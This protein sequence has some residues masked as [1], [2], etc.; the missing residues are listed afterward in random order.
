MSSCG[1]SLIHTAQI[2]QIYRLPFTIYQY[3]TMDFIWEVKQCLLKATVCLHVLT[4]FDK[5][6]EW[7]V[8]HS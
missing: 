1:L 7:S 8:N 2:S 3:H 4:N 5:K 6:L